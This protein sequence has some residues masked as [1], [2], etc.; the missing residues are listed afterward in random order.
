MVSL[1]LQE[2]DP[3]QRAVLEKLWTQ[4]R[5]GHEARLCPQMG[6]AAQGAQPTCID[7]APWTAISGDH[8]CSAR[9]ML[10][11]VLD[12]RWVIRVARS[13]ARLQSRLAVATRPHQRTNAVRDSDLARVRADPDFLSRAKAGNADFLI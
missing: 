10:G 3:A 7:Y 11:I 6:Y 2:L 12:S 8:S 13:G 9:E 1:A 4:A 5:A